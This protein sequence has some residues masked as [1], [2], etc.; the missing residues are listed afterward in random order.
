M[1]QTGVS[2]GGGRGKKR[3]ADRQFEQSGLVEVRQGAT[4]GAFVI[5]DLAKPIFNSA[6]DLYGQGKLTLAHFVEV[7]KGDRMRERAGGG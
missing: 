4:G 2:R 6:Y 1:E 3:F 5:C 7:R